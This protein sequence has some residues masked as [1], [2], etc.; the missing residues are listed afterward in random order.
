MGMLCM[1]SYQPLRSGDIV[2]INT[3]NPTAHLLPDMKLLEVQWVLNRL[4]ALRERR[5]LTT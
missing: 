4:T 3:E 2:T 1:S 5:I